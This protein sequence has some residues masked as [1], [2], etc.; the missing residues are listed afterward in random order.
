MLGINPPEQNYF[1]FTPDP[2]W[3]PLARREDK[4]YPTTRGYRDLITIDNPLS[5]STTITLFV[6]SYGA[7]WDKFFGYSFKTATFL[8][9]NGAFDTNLIV[10]S[11]SKI[12]VNE[13]LERFFNTDDPQRMAAGEGLP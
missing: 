9:D 1:V 4:N 13:M 5:H 6:D 2:A 11:Q 12:V 10:Q 3:P 8:Q 7:Y